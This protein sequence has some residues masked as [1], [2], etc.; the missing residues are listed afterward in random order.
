MQNAPGPSAP[1]PLVKAPAPGPAHLH[2]PKAQPAAGSSQTPDAPR[3]Q[4]H[5]TSKTPAPA[6][7]SL[8]LRH[9]SMEDKDGS[10]AIVVP[11]VDDYGVNVI[12]NV[13][14][15]PEA[16]SAQASCKMAALSQ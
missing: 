12:V 5:S 4:A 7:D 11:S 16:L 9:D 2:L 6:V 1:H 10:G 15:N 3:H 14:N 13:D 8:A